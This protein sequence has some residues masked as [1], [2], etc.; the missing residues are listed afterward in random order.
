M[1]KLNDLSWKIF[2]LAMA[3]L[4]VAARSE[5]L[6][7]QDFTVDDGTFEVNWTGNPSSPWTWDPVRGTWAV[8]GDDNLGASTTNELTSPEITV[9]AVVPVR[10][11]FAQRYSFEDNWDGGV[12]QVAV[13]GGDFTTVSA[14]S[15]RDNG[16]NFTS[17]IGNHVLLGKPAFSGTSA[18]YAASTYQVSYAEIPAVAA[19]TKIRVRF[20]G[21][22]DEY[23][24][25]TLPN[26][27]IDS[28][29]VETLT[30]ADND[31]LPDIWEEA[32]G[33]NKNDASDA[34]ADPDGD[35]L[36]NLGE[37]ARLTDPK[38]ADTDSDG[39]S[40]LV[41][42]NTRVWVSVQDRGTDPRKADTDGD[43]FGDAVENPDLATTGPAQPGSN[44]NLADTD[45][46][47]LTDFAEV[48][49]HHTSPKLE[50]TD[51]D[52]FNDAVE[53]AVATDPLNAAIYP[54]NI[55]LLGTGILGINDSI[56]ADAGTP[57][58][59]A[60]VPANIVD[61]KLD[62]RVDTYAGGLE[63]N[64]SYAG[65]I[66]PT[67][68]TSPVR[69][70]ELTL[71]TFFD[72]G[73]FG[74]SGSG[75]G[76]GGALTADLLIEP[77]VQVTSDGGV[78]WTNAVFTSDYMAAMTGHLIGG[79]AVAN[80]SSKKSTFNLT[81]PLAGINGVRIIGENG[82]PAD[83]NG[84]LGVF[85]LAVKDMSSA[86]DLDEDGLT[87]EEETDIYMTDPAKADTDGDGI[88]DGQEVKVTLTDPT[89][90]DTDNDGCPD[91]REITYGTDPKNAASFPKNIALAG[92]A[93]L[94]V[95]A[96]VNLEAGIS[97]FNAGTLV[98]INDNNKATRV[99][100]FNS[101]YPVGYVGIL[102]GAPR[103]L[104]VTRL[105]LNM[106]TF[107][108]G[109]WFGVN[110]VD[111]GAGGELSADSFLVE[112]EV[113]VTSDGGQTWEVAPHTSNYL[114]VMEGHRIGGGG[115]PNPSSHKTAIFNL[116]TPKA[117]INGIRIIGQE[118]GHA[119]GGFIG[120]FELAVK[121]TASAEDPDNDGLT[122]AQETGTHHTDPDYPDTDGDG[123]TDGDEVLKYFSNPLLTDS[124]GDGFGDS[125][126]VFYSTDPANAASFPPNIGLLGTAI[127]GVAPEITGEP[128]IPSSNSGV[129]A[130]INDGNL[131][132]RVDNFNANYPVGYIGIQ[133]GTPREVPIVRLELTMATFTD[134]GWFGVNGAGPGAG[135][136]LNADA[137]L[138]EPTLQVSRDAGS[139]WETVPH[140]SDYLAAFAGHKIGATGAGNVNPTSRKAV[141]T[142]SAAIY[143]ADG[144]RLIGREGGTAGGGFLGVF[145]LG[146]FTGAV[147]PDPNADEDGDG[148]TN[149]AEAIAGTDPEN[150]A[151]CLRVLGGGFSGGQLVISWSSVPGKNYRLESSPDLKTWST[152]VAIIPASVA[153]AVSTE[154][155]IPPP[156]GSSRF[157][158]IGVNTTP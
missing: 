110:G 130:N 124:D 26:W 78:T 140:T 155:A 36:N 137:H 117:G 90:A 95:A 25:G 107:T 76:A 2:I 120:V 63:P 40:D 1:H 30:D 17:L 112:P 139:T 151:D 32:Y 88:N 129:P 122:T 94:G 145:E 84:F 86:A 56:D 71:A 68:R 43:G 150:P 5:V 42:T 154:T 47:G 126:E 52:G 136:L 118:G 98:S 14:S 144:I 58:A 64:C 119:G 125:M 39:L 49:T 60:G 80:P 57:V 127:I 22:W 157:Y 106:A 35:G 79:G 105:E 97:S 20:L 96:E 31:G 158:R 45:G 19:G 153:P 72:G 121:D 75:P 74:S 34:T 83:G 15:F 91:G 3:S 82:G 115:Q 48:N 100:N 149:G 108:D 93:I 11:T 46:D 133:W 92:N 69:Q 128:G 66:W 77:T 143:G 61:G 109:G 29:K 12:L 4:P 27:E 148:Q 44:P 111:P 62:T 41:E 65:V 67:A 37:Y 54:T 131:A 55:A 28:V 13:G 87:N 104:A 24:R 116:T 102:W 101:A 99:D 89:K 8:N 10:I 141:F 59:Q 38:K 146:V 33:F 23:T 50:D 7:S 21:A 134:G 9:P 16:Y 152:D 132:T 138:L 123:L 114:T 156:A 53:I 142:P 73:W 70:L 51:G 103:A 147:T 135:G 6:L 81:P 85:E 18:G 113:Q